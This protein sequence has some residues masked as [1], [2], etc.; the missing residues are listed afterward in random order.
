MIAEYETI[1]LFDDDF[2]DQ[3]ESNKILRAVLGL[4]TLPLLIAAAVL[5]LTYF[6]TIGLIFL[7][8]SI[9]GI[10]SASF[11]IEM[12]IL[13]VAGHAPIDQFILVTSAALVLATLSYEL[14]R[15]L[16][17]LARRSA[18][19]LDSYFHRCRQKGVGI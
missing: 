3:P 2:I 10:A 9:I 5:I 13:I 11:A 12:L 8:V 14:L 1:D 7:A 15:G 19:W 16:V 4:L 17:W 18:A 6:A